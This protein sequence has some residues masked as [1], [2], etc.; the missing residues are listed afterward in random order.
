MNELTKVVRLGVARFENVVE[1][2]VASMMTSPFTEF[3]ERQ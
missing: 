2:C 1:L 3:F